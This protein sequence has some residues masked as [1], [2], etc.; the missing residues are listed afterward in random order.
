M[1]A[2]LAN[3]LLVWYLVR[4]TID[5][6]AGFEDIL[7]SALCTACCSGGIAFMQVSILLLGSMGRGGLDVSK[8]GE[9]EVSDSIAQVKSAYG[10]RRDFNIG[11]GLIV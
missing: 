4:S 7:V 2:V 8:F 1:A 5:G 3:L 6:S 11:A 10:V 9:D